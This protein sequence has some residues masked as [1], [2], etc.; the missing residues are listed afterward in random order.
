MAD[1]AAPT[2]TDAE[3]RHHRLVVLIVGLMLAQIMAAIESTIV[4][5]AMWYIVPDLGGVSLAP[6]VFTSYLLASTASTLLWGKLSD[7][8]GR[9]WLYYLSIVVFIAG[10]VISG[11]APSM[12][13]LVVGRTVQ[14]AG[15]GGL[16]TLS[17]TIIADVISP[18]ERGRYQG[19]M[20]AM[21][22]VATMLGPWVGGV[23]VDHTTWRWIFFMNLPLGL[24]GLAMG[25]FT[26]RG[27]EFTRREH[28]IDWLG[29]GLLVGWVTALVLVTNRGSAWGWGSPLTLGL[30]AAGTAGVVAFV[31]HERRASEPVLPPELFRLRVFSSTSVLSFLQGFGMFAVTV[32]LPPFL[33]VVLGVNASSSGLL[34]AP[35]SLGM[36]VGSIG[37]G[38]LITRTGRYKVFPVVGSMLM[39]VG[40]VLLSRMDTTTHLWEAVPFAVMVGLG[41][42]MGLQVAI[43]AVQ[44]KVDHAHLGVATSAGQFFRSLG[45]TFGSALVMTVYVSQLD[46][47]L[48]RLSGGAALSADTLRANPAQIQNLEPG[49]HEAVVEAFSRSITTALAVVIP[50]VFVSVVAAWLIPEYPLRERAAV[51][52]LDPAADVEATA[53][54]A[55]AT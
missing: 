8:L 29:A 5:N 11:L 1:V 32:L 24:A 26:L 43:L 34:I 47:W 50:F 21:F 3:I 48:G 23:I 9:R 35:V 16:F 30:G 52:D 54:P 39:T 22:A 6:W 38:Q 42:G 49:V 51:G 45:S 41:M 15:A 20:G 40:F 13:V 36:L 27:L 53:A 10:S 28:T 19:Y 2:R 17:M 7:L 46:H 31:V 25:V 18:R 4:T 12:L 14:G 44:N 55:L 33:Q 37:S